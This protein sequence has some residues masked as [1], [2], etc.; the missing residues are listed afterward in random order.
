MGNAVRESVH[1]N[2]KKHKKWYKSWKIITPSIIVLL[3]IVFGAIGFYQVNHFNA[4]ITINGIKVGGL[5]ADQTLSNLKNAVLKNDVYLGQEL[6]VNGKDTEMGF[7]DQDLPAIEKLLK[8]QQTFLP[9]SKT[10]NYSLKPS[11]SDQNSSQDLKKQVET[12]I[13][14]LNQGLKPPQDAKAILENGKITVTKSA[15]GEQYDVARLLQEYEKQEH[16]SEIHLSPIILE[17]FKEDSEVVKNE[18]KKLQALLQHTVDYKVQDQ[19]F[20]LKGSDL[21][22]NASVTKDLK[23]TINTDGIKEKITEINQVTV[24]F[25]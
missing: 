3:A 19:V 2:D 20:P 14:E 22:K 23:V 24:Y 9:S 15:E 18:E 8:S 16:A 4:N 7:S 1:E 11:N 13:T 10:E 6:I 21:I 25:K 17:P 12:K 5:T